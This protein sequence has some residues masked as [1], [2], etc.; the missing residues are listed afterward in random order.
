MRGIE[1]RRAAAFAPGHVT[2]IFAPDLGSS[3][4]RGRGSR[5]LGVVVESGAR[6]EAIW[7]PEKRSRIQVRDERGGSL[8]IT[9]EAVR[10]LVPAGSGSVSV[11]VRHE[12]PVGQGFGMSAAGTLASSLAVAHLL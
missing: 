10:H 2:G 5:G 12:L 3:D 9:E 4:P 6:S 11:L 1:E 8:P 7:Q